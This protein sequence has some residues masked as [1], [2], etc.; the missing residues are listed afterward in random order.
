MLL[1]GGCDVNAR[2]M[3]GNTPLLIAAGQDNLVC[4][5]ILISA[6]AD[7]NVNNYGG[8]TALMYAAASARGYSCVVTLLE[9]GADVNSVNNRKETALMKAAK[10]FTEEDIHVIKALLKAGAHVN[11]TDVF[12]CNALERSVNRIYRKEAMKIHEEM[13]TV[14]YAAGETFDEENIKTEIPDH[15]KEFTKETKLKHLSREAIRKHLLFLNPHEN[16]FHPS[17]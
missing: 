3:D 6:G 7:V 2:D 12:G 5:R 8:N 16:L 14:L 15:M 11:K 9:K 10:P 1:N 17:T 4:M 13:A